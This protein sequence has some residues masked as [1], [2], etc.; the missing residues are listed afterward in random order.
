MEF[1]EFKAKR[2]SFL[3]YFFT[4]LLGAII[5]SFLLLTFGPEAIFAKFQEPA[6]PQ[7]Q[8]Q[9]QPQQTPAVTDTPGNNGVKFA[10]EKVMPSVVGIVTSRLKTSVFSKPKTVQSVGSG[11]IVDSDGYILTNNHVAGMDAR[12]ITVL[13][14]DGREVSGRT[15][16]ADPI[17]DLSVVKIEA[18]RLTPATLGDSRAVSVGDEA[19]AVGN[20]LGLRFQRTVTAGVISAVNRTIQMEEGYFMEDLVQTDASINP[21]NS[22]GPL[23]NSKG[24]VV[25]INTVKVS[26]AEGIGF[27]IPINIAKPIINSIKEKGSFTAPALGIKG[28]DKEIAGYYG[29]KIDKGIYVFDTVKGGP[30]DDAGIREG[31]IITAINGKNIDTMLDLR[32]AVYTAGV[33]STISVSMITPVGTKNVNVKLE[34]AAS[35]ER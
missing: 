14:Q 27:A 6:T 2:P 18:D 7:P 30:A 17:L 10:A 19:I 4:G 29:Y 13:L 9:V 24:E 8:V 26:S 12:N 1:N 35:N 31:D 34:A 23:T 21:G 5:G 32:E 16:W 25:G 33:G 15:I 22:G 20:P 3:G 11:V 28:L